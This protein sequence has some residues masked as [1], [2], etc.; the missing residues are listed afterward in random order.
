MEYGAG[1]CAGLGSAVDNVGD[2]D[3]VYPA[4]ALV[5][6]AKVFFPQIF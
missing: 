1:T 5:N 6:R 4:G 2:V 3:E